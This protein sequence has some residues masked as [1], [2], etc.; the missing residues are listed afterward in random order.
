[1]MPFGSTFA[2]DEPPDELPLLLEL[3]QA[4]NSTAVTAT[5]AYARRRERRSV[6]LT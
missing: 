1:M 3:E 4:V 5:S 2:D 6:N